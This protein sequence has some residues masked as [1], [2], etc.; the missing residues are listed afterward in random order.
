MTFGR[1][2]KNFQQRMLQGSKKPIVAHWHY[3]SQGIGLTISCVS[4]GAAE[5]RAP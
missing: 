3:I 4:R 5:T 1:K 2:N